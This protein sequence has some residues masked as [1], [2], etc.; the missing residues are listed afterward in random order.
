VSYYPADPARAL[1]EDELIEF[2]LALQS[3]WAYCD[4]I[5]ARAEA[6]LPPDAGDGY[7][8]RFLRAAWSVLA[9]PRATET[10]GYQAMREA[11]L[12]TSR[13]PGLI[14]QAA[15]ILGEEGVR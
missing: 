13:L 11:V 15:E 6:G 5:T 14:T 3:V 10:G 2:E 8:R 12:E 1:A 7:G 9:N 4:H